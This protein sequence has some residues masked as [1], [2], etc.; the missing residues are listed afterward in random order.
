MGPPRPSPVAH[1]LVM[2]AYRSDPTLHVTDVTGN[3]TEVDAA[4]NLL[5]GT[6][7][8]SVLYAQEILLS[9]EAAEEAARSLLRAAEEARLVRERK[10]TAK[11]V[12]EE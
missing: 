9:P 4:V 5:D 11:A 12:L 8:L 1:A 3:E 7:R 10:A 2:S 6:V